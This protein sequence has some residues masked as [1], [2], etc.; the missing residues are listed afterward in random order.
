M[1][2]KSLILTVLLLIVFCLAVTGCNKEIINENVTI[3]NGQFAF[4]K[5]VGKVYPSTVTI[6]VS[7]STG[8]YANGAGVV[9]SKEGHILTNYHVVMN[10]SSATV[11][12]TDMNN[13]NFRRAYTADILAEKNTNKTFA[14]M[15]LAV[16]KLRSVITEELVPVELKADKCKFGELGVVIGNPKNIGNV[17]S[18]AMVSNPKKRTTHTISET[19]GTKKVVNG[20]SNFIALDASVNPG[21]SGGGFFDSKGRLAGLVTL[22][23]SDDSNNNT[24]VVFGLGLAI[25]AETIQGYLKAYGITLVEK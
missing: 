23:N 8:G 25:P 12:F 18:I 21:N 6:T 20:T 22:R 7:V 13:P 14:R 11:Y 1:K 17:C 24:N 19:L 15:D 10:A 5:V 3:E 16:L 9:I 4:E 2:K